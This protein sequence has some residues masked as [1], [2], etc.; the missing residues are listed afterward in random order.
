[1]IGFLFNMAVLGGAAKTSTTFQQ[2]AMLALGVNHEGSVN[3]TN[4]QTFFGYESTVKSKTG[5]SFGQQ[6]AM[7][8]GAGIS[9]FATVAPLLISGYFIYDGFKNDGL[10][11]ASD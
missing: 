9:R 3:V 10:K 1:M 7:K 11:G 8:S 5:S 2:G 4:R 6:M